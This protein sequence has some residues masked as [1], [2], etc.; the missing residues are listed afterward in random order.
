MIM[1]RSLTP[2][3]SSRTMRGVHRCEPDLRRDDNSRRKV[4]NVCE[5]SS[6]DSRGGR[7]IGDTQPLLTPARWLSD[8]QKIDIRDDVRPLILKENATRLL[9]LGHKAPPPKRPRDEL[10]QGP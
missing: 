9:G 4:Q 8:F 5:D 3:N 1:G 6:G 7:N 10:A 2:L